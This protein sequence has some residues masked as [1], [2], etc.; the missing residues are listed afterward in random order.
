MTHVE[1]GVPTVVVGAA[2]VLAASPNSIP[3]EKQKKKKKM[4][5]GTGIGRGTMVRRQP[6][7]RLHSAER[8]TTQY[9]KVKEGGYS[10]KT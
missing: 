4:I 2:D 6:L 10:M 5:K 8:S 9:A 7:E 3:H 1:S